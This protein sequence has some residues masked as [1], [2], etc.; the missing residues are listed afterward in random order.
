M[1]PSGERDSIIY[2]SSKDQPFISVI[3]VSVC[4][5]IGKNGD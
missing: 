1:K 4:A 5:V 2:H 3:L